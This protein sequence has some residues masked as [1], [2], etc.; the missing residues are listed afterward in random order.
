[1]RSIIALVFLLVVNYAF[2]QN[3]T[4]YLEDSELKSG[5]QNV[6]IYEPPQGLNLPADILATVAYKDFNSKTVPLVKTGANYEFSLK[7]PAT[8]DVL[9]ITINDKKKEILDT[10]F[11][12]GYVVYLMDKSADGF[13]KALLAKIETASAAE[14]FL[15]IMTS[16]EELIEQFEDLY[17]QYPDL[18][19][20]DSYVKYLYT[21]FRISKQE[22]RPELVDYAAKMLA[23]GDESGVT[24]AYGIYSS[25][26]MNA[27]MEALEKMA[28]DKYPN[29]EIAKRV[30]FNEFYSTQDKSEEYI[31]NKIEE[32]QA[33]FK[34]TSEQDMIPFYFP[35]WTLYLDSRDTLSMTKYEDSKTDR[36]LVGSIYNNYAWGLTGRDLT[37]A[38]EDLDFAELLSG[39]SL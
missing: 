39:N 8:I 9:I 20:D 24:I 1:M 25:L 2:S 26:G 37:S 33:R 23:K 16:P 34:D 38:G 31:L 30:F 28:L 15:K 10:N 13:E 14:Y 22:T 36:S 11:D 27:E 29:G 5:E 19:N 18:K 32:F 6:Y 7:V 17:A 12:K 3:G 4:I 21:K 35:L